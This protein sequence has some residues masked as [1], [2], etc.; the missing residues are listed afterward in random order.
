MP[1]VLGPT[2]LLC[3]LSVPSEGLCWNLSV[4]ECLADPSQ[5]SSHDLYSQLPR[6]LP[7]NVI[8]DNIWQMVM[9]ILAVLHI[10]DPYSDI[11]L[12]LELRRPSFIFCPISLE[13]QI[14][15]SRMNDTL[16][17]KLQ[18]VDSLLERWPFYETGL[19]N[20]VERQEHS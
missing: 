2:F 20:A 3:A 16:G 14:F 15:C 18:C 13:L 12:M 17:L 19:S 11:G 8:A 9:V 4:L 1:D 6:S 5:F 10:S 7:E